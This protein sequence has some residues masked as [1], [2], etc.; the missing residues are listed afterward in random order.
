MKKYDGMTKGSP[1]NDSSSMSALMITNPHIFDAEDI[2]DTNIPDINT[3]EG[4]LEES[5]REMQ[6]T[7]SLQINGYMNNYMKLFYNCY[8]RKGYF[9]CPNIMNILSSSPRIETNVSSAV[10]DFCIGTVAFVK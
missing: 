1:M 7:L 6:K 5:I 10:G 9:L 3:P 4:P 2:R 8:D